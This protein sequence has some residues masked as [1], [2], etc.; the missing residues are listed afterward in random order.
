MGYVS[1][2]DIRSGLNYFSFQPELIDELLGDLSKTSSNVLLI[3]LK[4]VGTQLETLEIQTLEEYRRL[5]PNP[6]DSLVEKYLEEI[7]E[8]CGPGNEI[9]AELLFYLLTDENNSRPL[10]AHNQLVE[11]LKLIELNSESN[12]ID[13]VL[14][15]LVISGLVH[16]YEGNE[17]Y[18]LV[19]DYF[20]IPIRKIFIRKHGDLLRKLS[21]TLEQLRNDLEIE[22]IKKLN[23][24]SKALLLDH[25]QLQALKASLK[26]GNK[27]NKIRNLPE[28]IVS[29]TVDALKQV[30]YTMDEYNNLNE[31]VG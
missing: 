13:V 16:K 19:H 26:S 12:Q 29:E 4:V 22:E 11:V 8:D 31:H 23:L 7:C 21:R 5:G 14:E 25:Q 1:P 15:I 10:K 27:L 17:S 2:E 30:V 28:K 9:I 3:E 18:Q 20:V 24:E 6:K